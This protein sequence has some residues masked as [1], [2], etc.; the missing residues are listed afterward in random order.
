MIE[1]A[2]A[3]LEK[4]DEDGGVADLDDCWYPF[5]RHYAVNFWVIGNEIRVRY[6][7]KTGWC[8]AVPPLT[9]FTATWKPNK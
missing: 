1:F 3:I 4:A 8:S 7:V 5:G 2:K 9:L 6:S